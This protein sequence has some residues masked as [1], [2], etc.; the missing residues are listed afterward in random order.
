MDTKYFF[1]ILLLISMLTACSGLEVTATGE[2]T[3]QVNQSVCGDNE[4]TTN[5]NVLTCPEDCNEQN[6]IVTQDIIL[7]NTPSTI[8][9]NDLDGDG[10]SNNE[11]EDYGTNLYAYDTDNDGVNDYDEINE[12]S[13]DPTKTDSDLDGLSDGEE[14]ND[15]GT[16]PL[17]PDSDNDGR[18][19]GEE[20]NYDGTDPL[21]PDSDNDSLL[22]GEEYNLG[23]NPNSEDSDNDCLTDFAEVNTYYTNPLTADTDPDND[24]LDTCQEIDEGTLPFESDS[25]ND[26]FLDNVDP[27]AMDNSVYPDIAYVVRPTEVIA[28]YTSTG[29]ELWDSDTSLWP[30][31][32]TTSSLITNS[33]TGNGNVYVGTEDGIIALQQGTGSMVWHVNLEKEVTGIAYNDNIVYAIAEN[34]LYA[35]DTSNGNL[36]WN[37]Q[38]GE[39]LHENDAANPII[40]GN[41][42]YVQA[43]Y[44]TAKVDLDGNEVWSIESSNPNGAT[45]YMGNT[46]L[47]VPS[48]SEVLVV[49][50]TGNVEFTLKADGTPNDMGNTPCQEV[51]GI[52]EYDDTLYVLWTEA[53]SYEYCSTELVAYDNGIEISSLSVSNEL[54]TTNRIIGPSEIIQNQ[55]DLFFIVNDQINTYFLDVSTN[56]KVVSLNKYEIIDNIQHSKMMEKEG[57]V[58]LAHDNGDIKKYE[59]TSV[60]WSIEHSCG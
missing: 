52:T 39:G 20:T 48:S 57:Y 6:E 41:H 10:I 31:P 14:I 51:A 42:I 28:L 34:A 55:D 12:Y 7:E 37:Y 46:H 30:D 2:A 3:F 50:S 59:K 54:E 25:D 4:C 33:V 53:G 23:T 35:Y 15:H 16:D 5:E 22:D 21:N 38:I 19:D 26:G 8:T 29:N 43:K 32:M 11:E 49:S 9:E 40:V 1:S 36:V 44:Y 13:T 24:E 56:N 58:Y 17:N 45:L 60:E 47:Y 18:N 27:S